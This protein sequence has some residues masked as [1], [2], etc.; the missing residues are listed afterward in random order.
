MSIKGDGVIDLLGLALGYLALCP[1]PVVAIGGLQ[2]TGKS[3]LARAL[4]PSLGPPPG[5]LIVR[6][7]EIRKRLFGRAPEEP[8]P[9]D[10]YAEDVNA[11]VNQCLV[12]Q[13]RVA[14]EN[15]HAVIADSTFLSPAM[16]QNFDACV[17][18]P[19]TATVRIWLTAPLE[20]LERRILQRKGDASDATV[21]VLRASASQAAT[22]AG[23][24]PVNAEEKEEVLRIAQDLVAARA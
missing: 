7:D 5:A 16:R 10:A 22:P 11:R 4:A 9:P 20:V 8:L 18:K 6:S 23:W 19:G 1:A 17:S 14:A 12:A 3:T 15:G 21:A 2:G 13:V 24:T